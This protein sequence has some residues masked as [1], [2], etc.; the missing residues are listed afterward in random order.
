M[1]TWRVEMM[2]KSFNTWLEKNQYAW[3]PQFEDCEAITSFIYKHTSRGTRVGKVLT[4][5]KLD[6]DAFTIQQGVVA[7][8]APQYVPQIE[9]VNDYA[10]IQEAYT[11]V[12]SCMTKNAELMAEFLSHPLLV[13]QGVRVAI[14]RQHGRITGRCL[15]D[16]GNK[17]MLPIYS[18]GNLLEFHAGLEELGFID[19][20]NGIRVLSNKKLPMTGFLPYLDEYGNHCEF[21]KDPE[22]YWCFSYPDGEDRVEN[23]QQ[24]IE[25]GHFDVHMETLLVSRDGNTWEPLEN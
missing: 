10:T 11:E 17:G 18:S 4:K 1:V 16:I 21:A 14:Y 12:Y 6:C 2:T 7:W 22:A 24:R 8:N 20:G 3:F 19:V 25:I 23:I 5:M 13:E 9:I 15:V